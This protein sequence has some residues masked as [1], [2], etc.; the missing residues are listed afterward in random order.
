VFF[1]NGPTNTSGITGMWLDIGRQV[2]GGGPWLLQP[3]WNDSNVVMAVTKVL[4]PPLDVHVVAA[5][6]CDLVRSKHTNMHG[7]RS[8]R[9]TEGHG[10]LQALVSMQ[11]L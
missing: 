9:P 10:P 8:H 1:W 6:A 11:A 4:W 3:G 7:M 5:A 2:R